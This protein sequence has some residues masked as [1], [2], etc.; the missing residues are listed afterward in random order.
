MTNSQ[1]VA[2]DTFAPKCKHLGEPEN[3]GT[4]DLA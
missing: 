4:D 3:G 2:I 1:N